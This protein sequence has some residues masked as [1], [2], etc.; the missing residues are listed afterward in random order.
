MGKKFKNHRLVALEMLKAT[1]GTRD[2][3]LHKFILLASEVLGIPGSFVSVIDDE[4]QYIRVSNN[5]NLKETSLEDAFCLFVAESGKTVVSCD[6]LQDA[7][8][9]DHP[10]THGEPWIRFYAGTPLKMADGQI[11][12]SFCVTDTQPHSFP[13]EEVAVLELLASVVSGYLQAW[14]H[15]GYV[16]VVTRLPNRQHLLRDIEQ[17]GSH[18]VSTAQRLIL[19]DCIA[20]PRAWEMARTLGIGAVEALLNNLTS[21]LRQ[22]LRLKEYD[23]LYTIATGRFALLTDAQSGLSA[24]V[25]SQQLAGIRAQISADI[26]LNLDISVGELRFNSGEHHCSEIFRRAVSALQE[27]ISSRQPFLEYDAVADRQHT[28]DYLLINELAAALQGAQG[29]YLVYQPK[30]DLQS[31]KPVGLEAL[32]R[33]RHPERGEL[34]PDKF[35]PLLEKTS[36]MSLLTDWVIEKSLHQLAVW[37]DKGIR[38]PISV[39]VSASDFSRAG[40]ADQLEEKMLRMGLRPEDLGIECLE[41]EKILESEAALN[42]LDMLKLRGFQI[43]LDDFGSGYSNISYLRRIPMDVIKLDRS[44]INRLSRDT[45]SRIIAKS[46][47]NLLKELD[48]RVLAEGVED[49][50]T[51]STLHHFGCD[52]AQGYYYSRPLPAA[53]LENWLLEQLSRHQ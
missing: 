35:I 12:G 5:F 15:A 4:R 51:A 41:T 31:G 52:E 2:E 19:I 9:A 10:L 13:A 24:S 48:Y 43:S 14:Y 44:L 38:L 18:S 33:W 26:A 1:D 34:P 16:D 8:F 40:F 7:R 37:K 32:I 6:T 3:I 46:V 21:L 36:L 23:R 42:G 29:L 39:N 17:L 28:D 22:R 47:I 53:Q 20:M 11:V 50:V 25:V 45:G 49:E 27:A 30:V